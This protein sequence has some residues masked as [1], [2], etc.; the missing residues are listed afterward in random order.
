MFFFLPYVSIKLILRKNTPH[1]NAMN[2]DWKSWRFFSR[3]SLR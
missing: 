3:L 2:S 1:N